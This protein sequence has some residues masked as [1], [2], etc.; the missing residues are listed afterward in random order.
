[1][2]EKVR[3][4]RETWG[5]EKESNTIKMSLVDTTKATNYATPWKVQIAIHHEIQL[6]HN[7]S[8]TKL[9]SISTS[10]P[11]PYK[12]KFVTVVTTQ[13]QRVMLM[14]KYQTPSIISFLV[15]I[16]FLIR[17]I[18][19]EVPFRLVHLG[20]VFVVRVVISFLS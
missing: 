4:K 19:V 7:Q 11:D 1:M 9:P 10:K 15:H 16:P 17:S 8:K 5:T 2:K 14:L 18:P 13:Y 20:W 12:K 6:I 3:Q